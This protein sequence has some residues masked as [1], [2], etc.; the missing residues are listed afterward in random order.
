M[1]PLIC[2]LSPNRVPLALPRLNRPVCVLVSLCASLACSGDGSDPASPEPSD[3][4][5]PVVASLAPDVLIEGASVVIRG[6]GFRATPADNVVTIDG[7]A[8]AVTAASATEL[9]VSVPVFDCRPQRT[10]SVQV[11]V[12][13]RSS[14]AVSGSVKPAGFVDVAVGK[15][16]FLDEPAAFCLQFPPAGAG[17]G[18]YLVGIGS[19]AERPGDV[20]AVDITGIEG[21][22]AP[23]GTNAEPAINASST[24]SPRRGAF[25]RSLQSGTGDRWNAH[26]N[27][28]RHIRNLEREYLSRS[29]SRQHWPRGRE[30][31][32]GLLAAVPAV[33][34]Q[35]SFNVPSWDAG[36]AEGV[37]TPIPI[38][39]VVRVVGQRAIFVSD[40]NNPTTDALTDADLQ[41]FSDAFDSF[42]YD[43]DTGYFGTPSDL[44]RNQ[45]II[46]VLTVEVNKALGG[47]IGGATF[48]LDMF[49][50]S[51]CA[52]SDVGEL[53]YFNVPDPDNVA[54]TLPRT[55][56]DVTG[57][58]VQALAHEFTHIIQFSTR[59]ALGP[60]SVPPSNWELEGQA[61]LAIEIVGHAAL[62]LRP[63][64]DYG[65]TVALSGAGST[66]YEG[67]M[68]GLAAYY[69]YDSNGARHAGAPESCTLLFI[70]V[71]AP[72]GCD[73]ESGYGAAWSFFRYLADRY[74]PAWPGGEA[75]LMRDWIAGH[76]TLS[77]AA[78]VEALL[79]RP[80][81][82]VF[83]EWAAMQYLDG[84]VPAA[85][86]ALLMSSWDLAAIMSDI[87]PDAELQPVSRN[88]TTFNATTSIRGGSTA[89]SLFGDAAP[90]PA[91]AIRVRDSGDAILNVAMRPHVWVVRTR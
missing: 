31:P 36:T 72:N 19:A 10:V 51:V 89:Y 67:T 29:P 47:Q 91:I 87:G 58:F 83:A 85:D 45:R 27:A 76:P 30:M 59:L 84:R 40:V 75:G 42:I 56:D 43:A 60:T 22:P 33:G 17:A 24:F 28:E 88:F 7:V 38:S 5:A 90:R 46:V 39:T 35:L 53:Y 62:G 21:D 63:G 86:P 57:N 54:G 23:A 48:V 61:N 81:D 15:L 13:G 78:N 2:R 26:A 18:E 66:W 80:F 9:S 70:D 20:F 79:G 71:L 6:T 11:S 3:A 82:A 77:G 73:P 55:K 68:L 1:S 4:A 16:L 34:E 41:A 8:A 12:S 49:D 25:T 37:C 14:N 64:Q 52:A 32:G 44:D 69:G 74:G 65:A 50:P